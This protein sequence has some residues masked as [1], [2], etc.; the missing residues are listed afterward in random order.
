VRSLG[1]IKEISLLPY[2]RI[3][4]AKYERLGLANKMLGVEPP[5]QERMLALKKYFEEYGFKVRI[6]G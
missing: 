4:E 5:S 6:G 1:A 3:A 2:H